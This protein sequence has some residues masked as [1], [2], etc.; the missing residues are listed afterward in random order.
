MVRPIF[1]YSVLVLFTIILVFVGCATK[2]P[3]VTAYQT[4]GSIDATATT[5]MDQLD[6]AA[7]RG[8]IPTNDIPKASQAYNDLHQA[9]LFASIASEQGTNA[10]A[11]SNLATNLFNLTQIVAGIMAQKH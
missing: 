3:Q 2:S 4:I 8:Q 5:I 10:V 9:L 11:P 6:A 1:V 7:I